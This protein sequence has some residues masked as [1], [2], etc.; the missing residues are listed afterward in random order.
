MIQPD[1]RAYTNTK[2]AI[3]D[4]FCHYA[5]LLRHMLTCDLAGYPSELWFSAERKVKEQAGDSL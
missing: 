3:S 5:R 4:V 2:S 1:I